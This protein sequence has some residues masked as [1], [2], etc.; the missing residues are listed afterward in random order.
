MLPGA[1]TYELSGLAWSGHG[2]IARVEVSAD[3]GATW[4]DAALE[5]R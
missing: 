4:A 5:A 3:G 1:G 2:A